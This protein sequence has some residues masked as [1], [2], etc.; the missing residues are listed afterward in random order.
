MEIDEDNMAAGSSGIQQRT[1]GQMTRE[2]QDRRLKDLEAQKVRLLKELEIK[3]AMEQVA[4]LQR[5]LEGEEP[6][7]AEEPPAGSKRHH[8]ADGDESS[9]RSKSSSGR[10]MREPEVYRG[11][12]RKAL[13]TFVTVMEDGFALRPDAYPTDRDKVLFAVSRMEGTVRDQWRRRC[14]SPAYT[15]VSWNEFVTFLRDCLESPH[16]RSRTAYS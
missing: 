10:K 16:N 9:K 7:V 3:T 6:A 8:S 12:S 2:E 13:D 4:L 11:Q 14:E 1:T 15:Q 5:R